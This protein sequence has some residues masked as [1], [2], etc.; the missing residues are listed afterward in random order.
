MKKYEELEIQIKELQEEVNRLKREEKE[1]KL[2]DCFNRKSVLSILNDPE[3]N[4]Y[5][6]E[7]AFEWKDTPQGD[8][9]WIE[10]YDGNEYLTSGDIIQLQQWVILSY[11][12]EFGK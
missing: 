8:S 10:I 6:L 11:Q 1:N 12:Q 4:V 5:L 9:Y 2:P 7:S 3:R